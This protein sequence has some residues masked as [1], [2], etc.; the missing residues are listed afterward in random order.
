MSVQ[1]PLTQ[2]KVA[3]IDEADYPY[4]SRFKW[5]AHKSRSKWY[6]ARQI[7]IGLNK[8]RRVFLHIELMQPPEG[9]QVD[10]VDGDGLNCTRENMRHSTQA[11]NTKNAARRHDNTSGYKGVAQTR[12]GRWMAYINHDGERFALGNYG[13]PEEAARAYDSRAHELHGAFANLNFPEETPAPFVK[14]RLRS[15]NTSGY[16]GVS[17]KKDTGTFIAYIRVDGKRKY[18]GAF[19]DAE[20]AARAFDEAARAAWGQ[21]APLNFPDSVA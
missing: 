18:L 10:H 17:L 2:G 21:H 6:A 8:Q 19:T 9:L 15:S 7:R 4:V 20:S 13:T 16:L 1:I 12:T 3:I 11:E 14:P 5:Y